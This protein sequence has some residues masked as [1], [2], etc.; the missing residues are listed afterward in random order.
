MGN[1]IVHVHGQQH[2]ASAKSRSE[3]V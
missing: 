1:Q 2:H 3:N